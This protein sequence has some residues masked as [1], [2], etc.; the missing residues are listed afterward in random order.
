MDDSQLRMLRDLA[1]AFRAAI[2]ATRAERAPGALPYFPEGACRMTSR[3]F[4]Q[5]LASRPD[6]AGFGR[7]QLVSGVLPGAEHATR[8]FWL[9]VDGAVVD[10]TADPFGVP[11][12][13]VGART[14]FHQSLTSPVVDD[15]V[16]S[17]A[18]LSA[19]ETA[20]LAR[21]LAVIEAGLSRLSSPTA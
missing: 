1:T 15:A 4:A 5:F 19:D 9:E 17:L 21:Q 2:E 3:L 20:R 7:P 13:V 11:P 10:L 18:A 14:A 12:V 8:H 6:C 16:T